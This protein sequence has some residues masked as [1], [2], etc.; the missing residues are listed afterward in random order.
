MFIINIIT[1]NAIAVNFATRLKWNMAPE[2]LF[3][4]WNEFQGNQMSFYR[5]LRKTLEFSDVTLVCEDGQRIEA[6][7]LVLSSSSSFFRDLLLREANPH[8]LVF[9]RGLTHST[10]AALV[11]YIYHGEVEVKTADL[12]EFLKAAGEL[13]VKGITRIDKGGENNDL[14]KEVIKE[15][16]DDVEDNSMDASFDDNLIDVAL[17][18]DADIVKQ[19][20]TTKEGHDCN[21]CGRTYGSKNSLRTH[22]YVHKNSGE[23]SVLRTQLDASP[24]CGGDQKHNLDL[25]VAENPLWEEK[26]DD[27]AEHGG[28]G[29]KCRRCGKQDRNRSWIR[30]HVESHIEGFTFPCHLCEKTF[31]KRYKLKTHM[32]AVHGGGN[33]SRMQKEKVHLD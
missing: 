1:F 30:R 4:Q 24:E 26:I 12:E 17:C 15:E 27:L 10:L 21:E 19:E 2:L 11:D 6:H 22:K 7:R 8:P 16:L 18:E 31:S 14:G 29:W 5:N 33:L 23:E 3:L 25:S 20:P 28:D 13:R 9:M 32:G